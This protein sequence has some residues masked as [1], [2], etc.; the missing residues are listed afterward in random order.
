MAIWKKEIKLDDFIKMNQ[1]TIMNVLGIEIVEIGDDYLRGTMPVDSRTFQPFKLLHGGANCVL[2]ETLGSY[3]ANFSIQE[4]EYAVGQSI[5]TQ[6][7]SPVYKDK[8]SG[9]AK[10]LHLGKRTQI[11]TIDTFDKSGRLNSTSK[12]TMAILQRKK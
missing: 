1:N 2:A 12:L 8:I 6:H 10:P 7:I 4:N 3:A 11:W 5:Y 9:I